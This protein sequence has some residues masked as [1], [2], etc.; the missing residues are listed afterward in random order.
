[1]PVPSAVDE[2]QYLAESIDAGLNA[3]SKGQSSRADSPQADPLEAP[4]VEHTACETM[5]K[6]LYDEF[7]AASFTI[8]WQFDQ[9]GLL[10]AATRLL[11]DLRLIRR[12]PGGVLVLPAA[13]RYR[14]IT[15]A[16]PDNRDGQGA[17]KLQFSPEVP[18]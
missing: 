18:A 6:E 17:F 15:A 2:L 16:L 11:D 1:M 7:G 8:A 4:F 10:D 14:N 12:L 5:L 13:A 3:G 9:P